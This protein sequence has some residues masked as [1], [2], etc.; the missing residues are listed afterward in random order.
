MPEFTLGRNADLDC[1]RVLVEVQLVDRH[2]PQC[3]WSGGS[4]RSRG[5]SGGSRRSCGRRSC[6]RRSYGMRSCN[7]RTIRSISMRSGSRRNYCGR[8]GAWIGVRGAW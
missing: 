1:P 2:Y 3:G 7:R 8:Q 4:S 5:R 6:A